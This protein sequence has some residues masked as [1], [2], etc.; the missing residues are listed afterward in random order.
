MVGPEHPRVD[1]AAQLEAWA[2]QAHHRAQKTYRRVRRP[3]LFGAHLVLIDR[4]GWV[5]CV[6]HTYGDP[7]WT[8][9]G[10]QRKLGLREREPADLTALRE[11]EEEL[12]QTPLRDRVTHAGSTHFHRIDGAMHYTS[13]FAAR[14]DPD[15]PLKP[16]RGEMLTA[17]EFHL[18]ALPLKERAIQ[19]CQEGA[20]KLDTAT[21]NPPTAIA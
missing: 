6:R 14:R 11:A 4:D 13:F 12:R 8:L 17:R 7:R 9:P 5:V 19:C 18:L 1:G 3:E 16:R 15:Q 10:G 21:A 20:R 2:R